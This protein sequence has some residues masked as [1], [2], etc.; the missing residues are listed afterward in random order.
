MLDVHCVVQ[1]LISR[2][3]IFILRINTFF[4]LLLWTLLI[5]SMPGFAGS[6]NLQN[7]RTLHLK[8]K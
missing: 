2:S 3:G 8:V 5:T 6:A 4:M 7:R 1:C